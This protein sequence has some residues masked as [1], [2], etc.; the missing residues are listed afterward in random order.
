M[1]RRS[2]HSTVTWSSDLESFLSFVYGR[3][4][5]PI[6]SLR[7]Y[8]KSQTGS[9]CVKFY[10]FFLLIINTHCIFRHRRIVKSQNT[11]ESLG[12]L[13]SSKINNNV[14]NVRPICLFMMKCIKLMKHYTIGMFLSLSNR[15][16]E[17]KRY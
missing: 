4:Y 5:F 17:D 13:W 7:I 11:F 16:I 12:R 2:I 1:Y 14:R 6:V 3:S 8:V 9:L 10:F 15:I